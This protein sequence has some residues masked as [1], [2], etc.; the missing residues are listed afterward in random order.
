MT[1]FLKLITLTCCVMASIP[2]SASVIEFDSADLAMATERPSGEITIESSVEHAGIRYGVSLSFRSYDEA[3]V[4]P[5]E[6]RK[7]DLADIREVLVSGA[8]GKPAVYRVADLD[9]LFDIVERTN[10]TVCGNSAARTFLYLNRDTPIA[11]DVERSTEIVPITEGTIFEA[12]PTPVADLCFISSVDDVD[13]DCDRFAIGGCGG[14]DCKDYRQKTCFPSEG[15]PYTEWYTY[16]TGTCKKQ[17]VNWG[18]DTCFC[19]SAGGVVSKFCWT[20]THDP[21]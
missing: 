2:L 18:L 15:W 7:V 19:N 21:C 10:H 9:S 16:T 17:V 20:Q 13:D 12:E 3:N 8:D 14:P 11:I 5:V 6:L 1:R 4:L